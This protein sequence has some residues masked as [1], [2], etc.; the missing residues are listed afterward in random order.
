MTTNLVV[1]GLW[2]LDGCYNSQGSITTV[3]CINFVVGQGRRDDVQ[4]TL[5]NNVLD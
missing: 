2:L 4:S 1:I 5:D 3:P